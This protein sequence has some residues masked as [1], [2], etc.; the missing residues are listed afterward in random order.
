M[1]GVP[2]RTRLTPPSIVRG[3]VVRIV[4]RDDRRITTQEWDL[5]CGQWREGGSDAVGLLEAF[6]G[7]PASRRILKGLCVPEVD[8]G[9]DISDPSIPGS[10]TRTPARLESIP[11]ANLSRSPGAETPEA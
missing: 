11:R 9:S 1:S 8:W 4:E 7:V 10:S 5:R 6:R 2:I 3:R